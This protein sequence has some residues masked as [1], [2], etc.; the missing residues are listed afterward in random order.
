VILTG[1]VTTADGNY[2]HISAEGAT[3]EEARTKLDALLAD[4][5][6]L[7]VLRTDNY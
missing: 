4:D 1:T 2:D 3:Y 6:K 7:I 5:Q